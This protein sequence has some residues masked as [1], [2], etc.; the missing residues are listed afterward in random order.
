M[1][2]E[3]GVPVVLRDVETMDDLDRV[4]APSP[5]RPGDLVASVE[6]T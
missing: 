3:I 6:A 1:E 2:L 4:R 5:V